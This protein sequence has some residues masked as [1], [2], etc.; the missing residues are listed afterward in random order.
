MQSKRLA[1][2]IQRIKAAREAE[3]IRMAR[4]RN[5]VLVQQLGKEGAN[6]CNVVLRII[7]AKLASAADHKNVYAEVLGLQTTERGV[8]KTKTARGSGPVFAWDEQATLHV[9]DA[10]NFSIR[11]VLREDVTLGKDRVVGHV[12]IDSLAFAGLATPGAV[13]RL[14]QKFGRNGR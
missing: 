7:D 10:G 14:T 8:V 5:Q 4:L 2:E 1:R 9:P 11:I 6:S 12:T 13:L 3:E